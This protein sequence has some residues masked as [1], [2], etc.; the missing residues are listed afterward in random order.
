MN[1]ALRLDKMAT[2]T[3]IQKN[4]IKYA[5]A[6]LKSVN[7]EVKTQKQIERLAEL[8]KSSSGMS[9]YFVKI[10]VANKVSRILN[11][12]NRSIR[13]GKLNAN[14]LDAEKIRKIAGTAYTVDKARVVYQNILRT[15]YCCG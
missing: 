6:F 5:I 4:A 15:G 1:S 10:A 13:E 12:V 8:A 11:T 9:D 7:V 2:E 14:N 3:E